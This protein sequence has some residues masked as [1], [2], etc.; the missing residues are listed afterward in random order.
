MVINESII[1]DLSSTD[2]ELAIEQYLKTQGYKAKSIS[3]NTPAKDADTRFSAAPSKG[4]VE[5]KCTCEKY[6]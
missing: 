4:K 1:I 5:A 3:F 2:I 6:G